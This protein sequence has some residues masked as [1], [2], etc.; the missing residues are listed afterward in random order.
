MDCGEHGTATVAFT[1]I[2]PFIDQRRKIIFLKN[3]QLHGVNFG[4]NTPLW[5]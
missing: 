2:C 1:R 5:S 4:R 3:A